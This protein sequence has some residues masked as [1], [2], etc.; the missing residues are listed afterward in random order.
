MG[1]KVVEE[2]LILWEVLQMYGFNI[3]Y[4]SGVHA[5]AL[6]FHEFIYYIPM[7]K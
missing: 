4:L 6:P 5:Q 3:I 7:H 2:L 1:M